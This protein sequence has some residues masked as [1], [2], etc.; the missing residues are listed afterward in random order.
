MAS[1][2]L[3]SGFF[4]LFEKKDAKCT[5]EPCENKLN[6]A[7]KWNK[8]IEE[9]G[10]HLIKFKGCGKKYKCKNCEYIDKDIEYCGWTDDNGVNRCYNCM[11][12]TNLPSC[13]DI[14]LHVPYYVILDKKEKD[15]TCTKNNC[16]LCTIE[17]RNYTINAEDKNNLETLE[18]DQSVVKKCYEYGFM[19]AY[20]VSVCNECMLCNDDE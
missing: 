10:N 20:D 4:G 19:N 16:F 2:S 9:R 11:W 15:C 12:L 8:T 5:C 18:I 6:K 14:L 17:F 13:G 3:L 7:L 1:K